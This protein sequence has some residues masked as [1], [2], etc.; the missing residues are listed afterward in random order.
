MEGVGFPLHLYRNLPSTIRT[1]PL[2]NKG[3]SAG[4][5]EVHKATAL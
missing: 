3:V 5:F 4:S 1:S 2:Q